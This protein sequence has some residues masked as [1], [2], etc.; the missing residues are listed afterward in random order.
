MTALIRD[1]APD[2]LQCVLEINEAAVPHVN[3]VPLVQMQKFLH[4]AAYFRVA[5]V[6]GVPAAFLVGLTP[7][8]DYQSLNFRWFC[9]RYASFAYIDRVAVAAAARRR[10]LAAA[11]YRD[12]E[13]AF[14]ARSPRLVCEVNLRPPNPASMQFHERMGFVRVGS[15]VIDDGAKEVA[16]MVKD[17]AD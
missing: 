9:E 1:V 17:L 4:E 16:M 15:Q 5:I 6:D 14:N 11:L 13:A 8:A 2:D 12:F 10:G 3:S 7:D